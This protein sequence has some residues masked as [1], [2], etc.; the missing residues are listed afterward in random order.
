[1]FKKIINILIFL[2]LLNTHSLAD[3]FSFE[4]NEILI[5]D[6]GN[7]LTSKDGAKITSSD[8]VIITSQKFEYSKIEKYLFLEE[9]V[10]V[11]DQLNNTIIEADKISYNRDTEKIV[12]YGKTKINIENKY[13]IN[14][15]SITFDRKSGKVFSK[16][17][18]TIE[19][20]DK[21]IFIID[22][23]EF[24]LDLKIL[25]AKNVNIKHFDGS[26]SFLESFFG[27][28]ETKEFF[29]KDAKFLF[30][31]NAF[32]NKDNDPRLYGNVLEMNKNKTILSKGIFTTCKKKDGCPSWEMRAEK[33]THDKEKKIIEYKNA[34]LELYDHPILYFPKFFHPDPTVKRQSGFLIPT[35]G[36]S[37]NIGSS[38]QIPYFKVLSENKDLTFTP[39]LFT[40]KDIL[41]QNEY[42]KV[43]KNY[44]HISDVG[45]FTS[46]LSSGEQS[47]KSH[48]F[49]N[50]KFIFNENFFSES[51]LEVNIET[52]SN[53]TYLKMYDPKSSLIKN[54]NTMH[55]FLNFSGYSSDASLS[56]DIESYE[57]L[58]VKGNDRYQ[59]IYPNISF[60]KDLKNIF[61][62]PGELT[63][64]SNIFQKQFE[65]NK[66]QQSLVNEIRYKSLEKFSNNGVLSNF[67]ISLKNPNVR[68]KIGS[69]N[70]SNS[71]NQ[72][73]SKLMYNISYPLQKQSKLNNNIFKPILSLRYSPNITKN[74]SNDDQKLDSN[75]INSFDRIYGSDSIEGG[76]SATLGF[77]YKKEN[78]EGNEMVNF[79]MY[80]VLRD[81]ENHDLPNKTTLNQKYSDIIGRLKINTLDN[82]SLQY[83][84]MLD[85]NLEDTNLNSILAEIT[86]NNFVTNFEFLEE[87]NL[88]GS[89][90]F[91]SNTT[92]YKFDER[93]SIKFATRRNKEIDLTEF[94]NLVYQY[95]NDCLRAA[96]EYN[97]QFY[98]DADIKPEEELFFSITIIPFS[99]LNS[100][101]IN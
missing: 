86:V 35:F 57:D 44:N 26:K 45:L 41:L 97:K 93:N 71:K 54:N 4:G 5:L 77:E 48:L 46:T 75:N 70:D 34:W 87:R 23:F 80:Q 66:Y 50:T 83:N 68:N 17:K 11:D 15:E 60:N 58:S 20:R 95:E 31:K 92:S 43:E 74:L 98:S 56:L 14:T 53:D 6:N 55:S 59:F 49:S 100:T 13:T 63:F 22:D 37:G 29:G 30:N 65:T 36:D 73:L 81:T 62:L 82:L 78:F 90:S 64:S 16:A 25:K 7:K 24:S 10:R 51:S 1:M 88:V 8:N 42:R 21:N 2:L 19:D 40:N 61:D 12:S 27:N 85:N 67:I 52:V 94:Y 101:N 33:V 91:I 18:T 79:E 32:G 72:L 47:S 96:L 99:K 3:E 84:F 28:L 76:Q 39:R 89:K 69:E 9:N 38:V